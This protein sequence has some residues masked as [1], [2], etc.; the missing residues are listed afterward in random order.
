[1]A[2]KVP[3]GARI[4]THP[5]LGSDERAGNNGA[6][7]IASPVDP[8][9]QI[10]CIASEGLENDDGSLLPEEHRWEHVSVSIRER[11]IVRTPLWGEMEFVKNQFWDREDCVLQFHPPRSEYVNVHPHVLHLW[12]KRGF[13]Q[14]RPPKWMVG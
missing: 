14:P 7:Q 2:F 12:R 6:F 10:F 9:I 5:I 13:A 8:N 3:E 1:M 11:G 4:R